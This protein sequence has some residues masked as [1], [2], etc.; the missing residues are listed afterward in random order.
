[1]HVEIG[2]HIRFGTARETHERTAYRRDETARPSSTGDP[3]P[4]PP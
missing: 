3:V 2:R 4:G 1:M